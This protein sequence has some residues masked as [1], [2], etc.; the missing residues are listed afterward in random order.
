M[1]ARY[2]LGIGQGLG[3]SRRASRGISA[4]G[5]IALSV[6]CLSCARSNKPVVPDLAKPQPAIA[7]LSTPT[8]IEL[9]AEA[10][11]NVVEITI[12]NHTKK[13][14]LVGPKFLAI[15]AE[16]KI[17]PADGKNVI[18]Q[19]LVKTLRREEGITGAFQFRDLASVEGQKLILKSP[20]AEVQDVTIK[21]REARAPNYQ[22]SPQPLSRKEVRRA[23]REEEQLRKALLEALQKQQKAQQP[24]PR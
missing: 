2:D 20:D 8:A 12:I 16:G 11:G 24:T 19:F 3:W 9:T 17:Y 22:T 13:D 23:Q 14:V 10:T 6:V 5:M 1:T 7:P 4:L 18:S 15:F 21:R